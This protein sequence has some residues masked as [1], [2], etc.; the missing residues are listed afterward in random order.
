MST[1]PGVTS[2]PAASISSRP[3]PGTG[4][5]GGDGGPV[6][7]HVGRDRLATQ[8]VGDLAPADHEVVRHLCHACPAPLPPRP[9]GESPD[10]TRRA[11][12]PPRRPGRPC[13]RCPRSAQSS[14]S[15]SPSSTLAQA[16]LPSARPAGQDAALGSALAVERHGVGLDPYR[17]GR[18]R[19]DAALRQRVD[20]GLDVA[21]G[22]GSR[23]AVRRGA[24]GV[25]PQGVL[26]GVPA[27]GRVTSAA[28]PGSS[29][30]GP[31][32]A[33]DPVRGV[34]VPGPAA[35]GEA[36]GQGQGAARVVDGEARARAAAIC[37]ATGKH[38]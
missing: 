22:E 20:L 7:R 23:A 5:D 8:S 1:K 26:R 2:K 13:G 28:D 17:T 10:P 38:E 35:E 27:R 6:D 14:A 34:V 3:R 18:R 11:T 9:P 30:Q 33:G 15:A 21:P 36:P 32:G 4:A 12:V 37:T 31:D 29:P 25:D 19:V 24:G 16:R